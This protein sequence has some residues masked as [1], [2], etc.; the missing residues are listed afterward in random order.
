MTT[1]LDRLVHEA[2]SEHAERVPEPIDLTAAVRSGV[3]R[4]HRT[5]QVVSAA[6]ALGAVTVLAVAGFSVL[7]DERPAPTQGLASE[8]RGPQVPPGQQPVSFHGL[9][10]FV[11][12]GWTINKTDR[13][14]TPDA[15]TV[16]TPF[17]S[18]LACKSPASGIDRGF[19]IA[20][21]I[22]LDNPDAQRYSASATE[23]TTVNGHEARRGSTTKAGR[24]LA[25]LIVPDAQ[26][27][28]SVSSPT[29]AEAREILDTTQVVPVDSHGCVDRSDLQPPRSPDGDADEGKV[30]PGSPSGASACRYADGW[31][32]FSARLGVADTSAFQ[33]ILN[34][35]APGQST[36]T[37]MT[38]IEAACAADAR[39]GF[40][41]TFA[42]ADREDVAVLIRIGGCAY[43]GA[44]NGAR[45][46]KINEQLVDT[47]TQ[48]LGYDGSFPNPRE[49]S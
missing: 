29:A 43:L 37:T 15:D 12:A 32:A 46:G 3:R 25:T 35:L 27:A 8:P 26:A 36:N 45:S 33:A 4:R 22:T 30:V 38:E 6:A 5:R 39:R 20:H 11:P 44:T 41:L 9:Q 42:Y 2:M 24:T 23:T 1:P 16:I 19:T 13:C 48:L 49:L 7:R 31:L 10:L 21:M 18:S 14:G 17:S 28:I 40:L 34:G 47:L